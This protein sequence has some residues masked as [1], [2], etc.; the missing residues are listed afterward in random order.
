MTVKLVPRRTWA[1]VNNLAHLWYYDMA[2]YTW[3]SLCGTWAFSEARLKEEAER[4]PPDPIKCTLCWYDG[5][6]QAEGQRE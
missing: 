2:R 3:R 5:R 6:Q 1:M 4:L